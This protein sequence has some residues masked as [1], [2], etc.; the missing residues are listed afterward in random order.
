MFNQLIDL[1]HIHKW[2][3]WEFKKY[4]S[5]NAEDQRKYTYAYQERHCLKCGKIHQKDLPYI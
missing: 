3:K 1:F 5:W 2:S 4:F